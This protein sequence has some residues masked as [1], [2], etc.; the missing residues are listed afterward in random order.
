[1]LSIILGDKDKDKYLKGKEYVDYN[2]GFFDIEYKTEWFEDKFIRE[3]L[4]KVDNIDLS[5]S[6]CVTF[7]NKITGD[8]HSYEKLSTS[9]KTVILIYKFPNVIFKARFGD[10]CCDFIERIASKRDVVLFS[11]YAHAYTFKYINEINYINYGVTLRKDSDIR[12]E[13]ELM[14]KF[15]EDNVL[16]SLRE[17][18][19]DMTIDELKVRHPRFFKMLEELGL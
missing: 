8:L 1:M 10:N 17:N 14:E 4:E 12:E 16:E 3:V 9:C 5:Q 6:S 13:L 15:R 7:K 19:D 11:G 2:D 18:E